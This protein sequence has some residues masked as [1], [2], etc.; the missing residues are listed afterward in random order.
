MDD[1]NAPTDEEYGD[2]NIAERPEEDDEEAVDNYLNVELIM[3]MGT[4]DERRGRVVKRS[5][6]LD[7]EPIGRAHTNPLFDT[8]E[9]E[10]EFTDGTHEK[11]QANVI[12]ENMYAQVDDEGNEFILLDEITDHRSDASAIPI[13][14]G[15][16]RSANGSEKP[17]KTTRGWFLLVQW[18]DGSV[19]REPFNRTT[20]L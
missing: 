3:N 18:K 6:G 4:N 9:Y 20:C 12:A 19:S 13:T 11:Y 5:R 17:K 8:R 15:T 7:G 14:D 16:I 2:M 10:V 1:A